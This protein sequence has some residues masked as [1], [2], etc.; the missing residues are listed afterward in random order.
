MQVQV[1]GTSFVL[2]VQ[3]KMVPGFTP[4]HVPGLIFIIS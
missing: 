2:Q 1:Q 4:L 3:K